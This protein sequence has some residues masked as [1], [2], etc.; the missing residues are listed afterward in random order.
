MF[1]CYPTIFLRAKIVADSHGGVI[2]Y[3]K[4][5]INYIRRHDLEPI[6]VECVLVKLTLKHKH[7]LFGLFNRPPNYDALYF[8]S[9]EDLIHL[10]VDTGIQDII[11][12][13]DF[14]YNMLIWKH[15]RK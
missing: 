15:H 12:T 11:V 5:H 4:D 10:A 13:G 3:I 8:S 2:I 1:L 14:N 9:I 6:G 7:I